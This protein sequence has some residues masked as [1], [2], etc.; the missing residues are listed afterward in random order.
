MT[1]GLPAVVRPEWR[2]AS[3]FNVASAETRKTWRCGRGLPRCDRTGRMLG[4]RLVATPRV[5]AKEA[6]GVVICTRF[7]RTS[8]PNSLAEPWRMTGT[9][10]SYCELSGRVLFTGPILGSA[11]NP[12]ETRRSPVPQPRPASD[13]ESGGNAAERLGFP[14]SREGGRKPWRGLGG[15]GFASRLNDRFCRDR[16]AVLAVSTLP[17]RERER[18]LQP[19]QP[20]LS[21][22]RAL[23][24]RRMLLVLSA[25]LECHSLSPSLGIGRA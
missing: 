25:R 19:P 10:A 2:A 21:A 20:A 6:R 22:G 9:E 11:G 12:G 23:T 5:P 7:V 15:L 16:L 4:A 8:N 3:V 17:K 13:S 18:R 1:A 24:F 14:A